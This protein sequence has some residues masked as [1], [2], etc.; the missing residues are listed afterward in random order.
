MDIYFLQYEC[1]P[2]QESQ[3]YESTGGAFVNCWIKTNSLDKAKNIAEKAI[4]ENKWL[5][6][7]VEE[8]YKTVKEKIKDEEALEAYKQAEQDEEVYIYHSWPNEPQEED[9]IH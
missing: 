4:K 9:S 5:V 2:S 7:G 8:S 1:I 3:A 6:L